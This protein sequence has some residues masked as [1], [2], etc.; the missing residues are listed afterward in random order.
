MRYRKHATGH[1]GELSVTLDYQCRCN[2]REVLVGM[3]T[4]GVLTDRQAMADAIRRLRAE[5]REE[6]RTH[7]DAP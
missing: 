4:F 3:L 6:M 7:E 1:V 5:M 2:S